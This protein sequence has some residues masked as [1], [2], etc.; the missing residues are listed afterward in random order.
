MDTVA[1][2][3]TNNLSGI[4]SAV[5]TLAGA[6]AVMSYTNVVLA[7]IIIVLSTAFFMLNTFLMKNSQTYFNSQQELLDTVNAKLFTAT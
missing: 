4:I 3:V 6:L 7:L 5:V 1:N 2:T